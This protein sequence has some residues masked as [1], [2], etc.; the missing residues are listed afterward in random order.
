MS[1][2]DSNKKRYTI[3]LDGVE[4]E[5]IDAFLSVYDPG[6]IEF[7]AVHDFC[8]ALVF[9]LEGQEHRI[10]LTNFACQSTHPY[11]NV[12]DEVKAYMMEQAI[13]GSPLRESAIE[14]LINIHLDNRLPKM[15]EIDEDYVIKVDRGYYYKEAQELYHW[16]LDLPPYTA[17]DVALACDL[18]KRSNK[19]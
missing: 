19:S 7:A 10:G 2:L 17:S 13:T 15:V 16:A 5:A 3:Q 14:L 1:R 6:A 8:H 11:D 4:Q 9:A 12:R 18:L